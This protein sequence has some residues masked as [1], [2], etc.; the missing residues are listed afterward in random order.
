MRH[1]KGPALTE[2]TG[3]VSGSQGA[4]IIR[5]RER[6]RMRYIG[7][8]TSTGKR[9]SEVVE[10][11][12]TES[13]RPA[14][15]ERTGRSGSGGQRG[16]ETRRGDGTGG[17]RQD[18]RDDAA[19]RKA[20]TAVG[21]ALDIRSLQRPERI[22]GRADK[23]ESVHSGGMR[24]QSQALQRDQD[25]NVEGD[26]RT[27]ST[28]PALVPHSPRA[29][30]MPLVN[31]VDNVPRTDAMASTQNVRQTRQ[32]R[33]STARPR[34]RHR[35]SPRR[36]RNSNATRKEI[37]PKR[38]AAAAL[39]T[40]ALIAVGCGSSP[41]SHAQKGHRQ[42]LAHHRGPPVRPLRMA[43]P[44]PQPR[45]ERT[46]TNAVMSST[47]RACKGDEATHDQSQ[48]V[49]ADGRHLHRR[50]LCAVPARDE[51]R[52]VQDT[53]RAMDA[54]RPPHE[55]PR[56]FTQDGPLRRRKARTQGGLK[57]STPPAT[58]G[59]RSKMRTHLAVS[60]V[61]VDEGVARARPVNLG[62]LAHGRSGVREKVDKGVGDIGRRGERRTRRGRGGLRGTWGIGKGGRG[63]VRPTASN[64]RPA[65]SSKPPPHRRKSV[66]ARRAWRRRVHASPLPVGRAAASSRGIDCL[67]SRRSLPHPALPPRAEPSEGVQTEKKK[68]LLGCGRPHGDVMSW[69]RNVLRRG[70]RS[71]GQGARS[72]EDGGNKGWGEDGTDWS[73]GAEEEAR[74]DA[75][76]VTVRCG[77]IGGR[78]VGKYG[79]K[80]GE[81]NG[82]NGGEE[83]S[84]GSS[85]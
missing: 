11:M 1:H 32:T 33:S 13:W 67:Q 31:A 83:D 80:G 47:E 78:K 85:I 6:Q 48:R 69:R 41:L 52:H 15:T 35:P 29:H 19:E 37:V 28:I 77:R 59:A 30:A 75:A 71:K 9:E 65:C 81:G 66:R 84:R 8:S 68:T 74:T 23:R 16:G 63:K 46:P 10:R 49:R 36:K 43:A 12:N 14:L 25:S 82:D 5:A 70:G 50:T 38:T 55:P 79:D 73:E 57:R 51:C 34:A 22:E 4:L 61:H 76:R 53:T 18:L 54:D 39:H 64:I 56:A 20:S 27:P 60:T 62:K 45:A 42:R 7:M 17:W 3:G 58:A 40:A 21:D 44:A 24:A 2:E 72:K 26:M